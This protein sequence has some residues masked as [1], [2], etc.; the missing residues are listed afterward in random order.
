MET[1]FDL[2][3][4]ASAICVAA[5]VA[6]AFGSVMLH[7]FGL[8]GDLVLCTAALAAIL[9]AARLATEYFG[10]KLSNTK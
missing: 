1:R 2:V 4:I 3:M 10:E 9:I 7:K 5:Y 6:I 8:T